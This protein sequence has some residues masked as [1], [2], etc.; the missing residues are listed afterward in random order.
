MYLL[1]DTVSQ[2]AAFVFF[3]ADRNVV[4]IERED[5]SGKEFERFLAKMTEGA[6]KLGLKP[7]HLEGIAC[8]RGPAGFT[9][10]RVVTLTLGTLAFAVG[11]P[12][13]ELDYAELHALG[14]WNGGVLVRAN[15]D[16]V[17][18]CPKAG[19]E[20]EIVRKALL[21]EGNYRGNVSESDFA[22]RAI[23]VES[24]VNYAQAVRSLDLSKPLKKIE[25]FY[26]KK[27]NVT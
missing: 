3:D 11:I 1:V 24:Q 27:P 4:S 9:G 17:A 7:K 26:V 14:G 8:V 13:F 12:L 20:F 16:E 19:A 22:G 21:P 6:E 25:P 15:R 23:S 10:I 2:P 18:H 5:L